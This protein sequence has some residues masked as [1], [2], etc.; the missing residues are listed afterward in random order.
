[1]KAIDLAIEILCTSPCSP[2]FATRLEW[3]FRKSS[4]RKQMT[5]ERL[6]AFYQSNFGVG[7]GEYS[8]GCFDSRRFPRGTKIGRYCSVAPSA[9]RFNADHPKSGISTHP[10]LY[11]AD[12]GY[13]E[14]SLER[15]G[16]EIADDVW[17]G[18]NSVL[19]SAVRRIGRGAIVGAGAIVTSNVEPYTVVGGSPAR[20]IGIRFSLERQRALEDSRW[21]ELDIASLNAEIQMNRGLIYDVTL[22]ALKEFNA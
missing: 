14:D 8:Y 9:Y 13:C 17:L 20:Q 7:I 2:R 6:R 4:I 12:L 22:E 15:T 3:L 5:S 21:W 16:C 18:H 1:M 19:T 11:N 10:F